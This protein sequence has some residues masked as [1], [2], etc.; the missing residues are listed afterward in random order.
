MKASKPE[1]TILYWVWEEAAAS[2]MF[3]TIEPKRHPL[4]SDYFSFSNF[5]HW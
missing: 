3:P 5:V 2:L 1:L 4:P